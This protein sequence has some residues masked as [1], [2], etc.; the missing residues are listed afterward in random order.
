MTGFR[1]SRRDVLAGMGAT[2]SVAVTGCL[3]RPLSLGS[4]SAPSV[5]P[6]P[7]GATAF[8]TVDVAALLGSE[9]LR[10]LLDGSLPQGDIDGVSD[11]IDGWI[12][13]D[14][15]EIETVSGFFTPGEQI[16]GA[17]IDAAWDI[18]ETVSA[19]ES[20]GLKTAE[21]TVS[22]RRAHTFEMTGLTVSSLPDGRTVA[23]VGGGTEAII[24][25][26]AGSNSAIGAGVRRAY[27]RVPSGPVKFAIDAGNASGQTVDAITQELPRF[28]RDVFESI[29]FVAGSL[30]I[31]DGH[32]RI[33]VQ[34]TGKDGTDA[35]Q[36]EEY[37][38]AIPP[39]LKQ[40]V[41]DDA[42]STALDDA[43]VSR[44][45]KRVT[46]SLLGRET[47]QPLAGAVAKRVTQSVLSPSLLG[48]VAST[49]ALLG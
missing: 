46:V 30:S 7:A 37:V 1:R 45:G 19:F 39:L 2:A 4:R 27:D 17:V 15:R 5:G 28:A 25:T 12:G 43:S 40:R 32:P 42:V 21:T 18:D 16:S 8:G 31:V 29:Q 10:G 26:D 41:D 44:D 3:D 34:V 9:P 33:R 13:L 24:A 36:L 20:Q 14:P 6:V 49:V 11:V 22:G 47:V 38:E 23:G 35:R 48:L